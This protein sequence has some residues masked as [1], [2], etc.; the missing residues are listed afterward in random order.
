MRMIS[1]CHRPLFMHMYKTAIWLSSFYCMYAVSLPCGAAP[2][3]DNVYQDGITLTITNKPF[4]KKIHKIQNCGKTPCIIDGKFFYGGD[5]NIPKTEVESLVFSKNG[6]TVKLDVSSMYD[7]GVN[8]ENIKKH[9]SVEP[10]LGGRSYR[11]VGYFGD[12]E[13]PYIV[14]W[15][16]LPDGSVRN[17]IG[18]YESLVS[19][20]FKVKQDFKITD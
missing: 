8:N 13:E 1:V 3:V 11:V 16:V 18:D 14:H 10:W 5:G 17:H 12:G 2:A 4:D 6:K 15:L 20:L 19:L 9:I 7:T